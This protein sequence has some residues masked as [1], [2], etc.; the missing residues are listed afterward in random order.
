MSISA[1]TSTTELPGTPREG[2]VEPRSGLLPIPTTRALRTTANR[3]PFVDFLR[4]VAA[5]LIVAHH[6]A[7]YGPLSNV[8]YPLVPAAVD[9]FSDYARMA[10]HAFLVI[11][12]FGTAR[13]LAKPPAIG[14]RELASHLWARYRRVGL[15]Y[16]AALVL[17]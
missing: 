14:T 6:L 1:L 16:L 11:G 13:R 8:A 15:P 7:F 3:L 17:A 2:V 10:V 5:L 4:G 12:G 9:W